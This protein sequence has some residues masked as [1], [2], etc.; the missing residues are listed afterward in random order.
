MPRDCPRECCRKPAPRLPSWRLCIQQGS[1]RSTEMFPGKM[2]SEVTVLGPSL[3]WL[4]LRD[5]VPFLWCIIN[6][7]KFS[8]WAQHPFMISQFCRSKIQ[9][10]LFGFSAWD[11]LRWKSRYWPGW[12]WSGSQIFE[13]RVHFQDHSGSCQ[14]S[15]PCRT[16]VP[17]FFFF[18]RGAQ[19]QLLEAVLIS[20]PWVPFHLWAFSCHLPGESPCFYRTYLIRSGPCGLFPYLEVNCA[21][22][23]GCNVTSPS[24]KIHLPYE[25]GPRGDARRVY[26]GVEKSQMFYNS[27][28]PRDINKEFHLEKPWRTGSKPMWNT[29]KF[30][31]KHLEMLE[32][33]QRWTS[34][35]VLMP[36]YFRYWC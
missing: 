14:N 31:S 25:Y 7:H 9:V 17:F 15:G 24:S 28:Y 29:P 21:I 34:P 18:V 35:D 3:K 20:Y 26:Q 5:H 36:L 1:V 32:K 8:G 2:L 6:G 27:A 4:W 33:G 16:E 30:S 22:Y 13:G 12:L 23:H 10:G 19:F 11:L